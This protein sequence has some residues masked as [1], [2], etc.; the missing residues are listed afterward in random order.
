MMV[1]NKNW[2]IGEDWVRYVPMTT[3][4]QRVTCSSCCVG[5]LE[6][7]HEIW[8]KTYANRRSQS[9]GLSYLVIRQ[10]LRW[11]APNL[12]Y[13]LQPPE[14]MDKLS[15]PFSGLLET[16]WNMLKHVETMAP[17]RWYPIVSNGIKWFIIICPIWR[18]HKVEWCG[19]SNANHLGKAPSAWTIY[20]KARL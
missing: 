14:E 20:H 6:G 2:E 1:A 7:S 4:R 18:C 16:C 9:C 3:R 11:S 8:W 17:P 13:K 19:T 10:W 5:L 12:L 15:C